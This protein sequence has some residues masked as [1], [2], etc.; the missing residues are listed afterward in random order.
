M[1]CSP[2]SFAFHY[3]LATNSTIAHNNGYIKL[4]LLISFC[5]F[6]VV[7]C[8]F[9]VVVFVFFVGLSFLSLERT[10]VL[11]HVFG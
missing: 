7:V 3:L 6:V 4:L 8:L 1:L 2:L 9:I 10:E 5:L 11:A